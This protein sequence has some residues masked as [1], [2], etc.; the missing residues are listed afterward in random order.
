MNFRGPFRVRADRDKPYPE[1]EH[2]EEKSVERPNIAYKK[3]K[4]SDRRWLPL[5][6]ADRVGVYDGLLEDLFQGKLSNLIK[7]RGWD[8]EWKYNRKNFVLKAATAVAAVTAVIV[9]VFVNRESSNHN[10][11]H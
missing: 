7:E 6:L 10:R 3:S 1:I 8:S 9:G 4:S 5:V 11:L 2:P